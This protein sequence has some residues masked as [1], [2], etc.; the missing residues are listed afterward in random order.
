MNKHALNLIACGVK[1]LQTILM[2]DDS[3]SSKISRYGQPI[4]HI[5]VG[6]GSRARGSRCGGEGLWGCWAPEGSMLH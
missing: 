2:Y 1:I 6:G 4:C 3:S 5:D